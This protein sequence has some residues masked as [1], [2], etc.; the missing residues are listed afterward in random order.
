MASCALCRR[1]LD[2]AATVGTTSRHGHPSRRVACLACSLV[3]VS[4]QPTEGE[5]ATYYASH[6]YRTEHGP[7]PI[8]VYDPKGVGRRVYRPTDPDYEDGLRV[9]ATT[10]R[11]W[12]VGHAG[13][14]RGMRLLEIGSGSGHTLA[15]FAELGLV[16]TGIEPDKEEARQSAE[17]LPP[18]ARVI[19]TPYQEAPL[20][21]PY[22]VIVAFHVLEHLHDPVTALRDWQEMLTPRGALVLEVPNLL[23]PSLPVDGYH[24]QHVHLF[25]FERQTLIGC[26]SKA[27]LSP[28]GVDSGSV[29]LKAV[30]RP[31]ASRETHS[32]THGGEYV[33]GYLDSIRHR[34]VEVGG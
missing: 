6:A 8:R 27:G 22:D 12:S 13:L 5:L 11:K 9:M 3:Q 2:D 1:P 29:S 19:A 24:W 21:P 14:V 23:K 4:P 17:R 31:A 16:C 10:R 33:Q 30:S 25:D 7:V 28:I 34:W 26:L 18:S 32:M 15:A 20:E